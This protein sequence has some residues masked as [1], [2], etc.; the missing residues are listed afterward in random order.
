MISPELLE[1]GYKDCDALVL[2]YYARTEA[3]HGPMP[4]RIDWD[5]YRKMEG[6]GHCCLFTA[7]E[8][9]LDGFALYL[10]NKHIHHPTY[11]I[12]ACAILG[13]RPEMRGRGLGKQLIEFAM[14]W[15][16]TR[17]C[18]HITHSFRTIYDNTKPL[19]PK[20]G[21]KLVEQVYMRELP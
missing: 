7:R 20:L 13:V 17:G 18:T 14:P 15:L 11:N 12:A 19:F 10:V 8:E 6:T 3:S 5:L 16:K 1:Q 21:F 2:D 4:L 9:T